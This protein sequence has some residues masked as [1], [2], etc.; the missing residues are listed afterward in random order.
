MQFYSFI[1]KVVDMDTVKVIWTYNKPFG[2]K[3]IKGS[4]GW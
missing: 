2:T 1:L 3:K 4:F